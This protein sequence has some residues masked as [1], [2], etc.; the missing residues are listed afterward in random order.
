MA[1]RIYC[2]FTDNSSDSDGSIASRLSDFGDTSSSTAQNPSHTYATAGT[3]TVTLLV[4]DN[5][6]ATNSASSEIG[7]TRTGYRS[8]Y[9]YGTARCD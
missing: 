2:S 4:T 1:A 5:D 3:Y 7:G 8:T 9:N 6:D